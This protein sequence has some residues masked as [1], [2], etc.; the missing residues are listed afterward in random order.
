[1]SYPTKC[2]FVWVA[3]VSPYIDLV[4][5]FC[6]VSA[7]SIENVVVFSPTPCVEVPFAGDSQFQIIEREFKFL[8]IDSGLR[9]DECRNI[10]RA[11]I[12]EIEITKQ[13]ISSDG[14]VCPHTKVACG[15]IAAIL[16]SYRHP[17]AADFVGVN[18]LDCVPHGLKWI[19]ERP[20]CMNQGVS[21]QPHLTRSSPRAQAA[22]N[23]SD[24][25]TREAQATEPSL[26]P[27]P[28]Y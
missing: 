11:L 26:N 24:K 8:G 25:D 28:P 3:R 14:Q 21:A 15:G 10:S 17:P 9:G 13:S 27:R 18:I 16:P 4:T 19:N 22:K 12:R 2:H 23:E 5:K 1:V 6:A 7:R 20:I